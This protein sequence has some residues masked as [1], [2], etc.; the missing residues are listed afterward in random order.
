MFRKKRTHTHFERDNAGAVVDTRRYNVVGGTKKEP[1]PEL[2]PMD[3]LEADTDV[4]AMVKEYKQSAREQD[5]ME[6]EAERS[7][8]VKKREMK[9]EDLKH[10]KEKKE[11][12]SDIR[13]MK[14]APLYKTGSGL[15]KMGKAVRERDSGFVGGGQDKVSLDEGAVGKNGNE[16]SDFF[17]FGSKGNIDWGGSKKTELS[18]ST[19]K[20]KGAIDFGAK[21]GGK[22][23]FN[24]GMGQKSA[25][26]K[27]RKKKT[28]KKTTKRRKKT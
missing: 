26:K 5:M 20:G 16:K 7:M 19:G 9:L 27:K 4:K 23:D 2:E 17:S 24:L 6:L 13:K 11:L 22:I 3:E 15:M 1:I 10:K 12:K 21:S 8:L 25:P 18:M 28:K 14:Y